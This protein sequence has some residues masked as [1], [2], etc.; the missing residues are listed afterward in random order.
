MSN[1]TVAR[2]AAVGE[3]LGDRPNVVL[4]AG[5]DDHYF[6]GARRL[7]FTH[8]QASIARL[9]T[10]GEQRRLDGADHYTIV[11]H[12]QYAR[13]VAAVIREVVEIATVRRD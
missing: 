10:R 9:S 12:E 3:S 4:S 13:Q 5:A 2:L 7:Q 8:S 1:R 11:T 6:H